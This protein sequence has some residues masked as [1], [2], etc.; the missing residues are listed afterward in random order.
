MSKWKISCFWFVIRL[1][2]IILMKYISGRCLI[3]LCLMSFWKVYIATSS[4]MF[5]WCNS[6]NVLQIPITKYIS[7]WKSVFSSCNSGRPGVNIKLDIF[8]KIIGTSS[9]SLTPKRVH[10]LSSHENLQCFEW[11]SKYS[12]STGG[13]IL[14]WKSEAVLAKGSCSRN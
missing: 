9:E 7:K 3:C 1:E 4:H 8:N 11:K 2:V 12:L 5:N 13:E 10:W 6:I 14:S